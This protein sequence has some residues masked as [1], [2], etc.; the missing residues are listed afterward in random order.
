MK[1]STISAIA[2]VLSAM[3]INRIGDKAV[4]VALLNDYLAFRKESKAAE[5]ERNE[6]VSKFQADWADELD[7]VEAFRKE[8]RPVEGHESFLA[9]EKDAVEAIDAIYDRDAEVSVTKVK[10]SVLYDPDIWADDITLAQIP[11][12]I[13]FLIGEGVAE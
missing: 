9:A 13:E 2:G 12:T 6:I 4:K 3:K 7:A 11:G 1:L 8:G 10:S 5:A